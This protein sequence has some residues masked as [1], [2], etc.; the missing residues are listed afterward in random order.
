MIKSSLEQFESP[1]VIINQTYQSEDWS[2]VASY[3]SEQDAFDAQQEGELNEIGWHVSLIPPNLEDIE[4]EQAFSSPEAALRFGI[5]EI[6]SGRHASA[7]PIVD[8]VAG[9]SHPFPNY[10]SIV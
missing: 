6:V 9:E 1:T 3:V 10:P 2:V 5:A 8:E 7:K 4:F